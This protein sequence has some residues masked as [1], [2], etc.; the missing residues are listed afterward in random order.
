MNVCDVTASF[1]VLAGT[2]KRENHARL[3]CPIGRAASV[4]LLGCLLFS[5]ELS[6]VGPSLAVVGFAKE[7]HRATPAKCNVFGIHFQFL[8]DEGQTQK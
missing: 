7:P 5:H 8:G 6:E 2:S 3:R 1:G 4:C